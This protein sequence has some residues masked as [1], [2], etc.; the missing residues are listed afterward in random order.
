MAQT[1]DSTKIPKHFQRGTIIEGTGEFYSARL[2]KRE[3]KQTLAEELAADIKLKQERK[4]RY[5]RMQEE[6]QEL[7]K[8]RK[9]ARA[10]HK[11]SKHRPKH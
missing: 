5:T 2:T 1:F 4:R 9:K 10:L 11:R 6:K 8:K 7:A 3:R